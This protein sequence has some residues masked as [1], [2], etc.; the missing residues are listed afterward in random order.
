MLWLCAFSMLLMVF[1]T[2][3]IL[4]E[5]CAGHERVAIICSRQINEEVVVIVVV[6]LVFIIGAFQLSHSDHYAARLPL[7]DKLNAL[8][9][10]RE[11]ETV[12]NDGVQV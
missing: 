5:S 7:P 8:V 3:V 9:Y 2:S 11:R 6:V 10:V 12:G 4:S 1:V